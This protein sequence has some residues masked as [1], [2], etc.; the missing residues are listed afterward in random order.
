[1]RAP[2][3]SLTDGGSSIPGVLYFSHLTDILNCVV[4][5]CEPLFIVGDLD[6]RFDRPHDLHC[7][8]R[9]DT[10]SCRDFHIRVREASP[11]LGGILSVIAFRPDDVD[12]SMSVTD[13]EDLSDHRL[14]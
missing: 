7:R 12:S 10:F 1:M 9:I 13:T 14:P 8:R 5:R 4:V 3:L 2:S 6:V 11:D